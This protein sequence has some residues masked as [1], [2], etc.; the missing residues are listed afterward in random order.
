MSRQLDN[1]ALHFLL[2]FIETIRHKKTALLLE[3][4]PEAQLLRLATILSPLSSFD[5]H[6]YR[7][8]SNIYYLP[9]S[10]HNKKIK[11]F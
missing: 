11:Y 8:V 5:C 1:P 9:L 4:S 6:L 10:K 3:C 2:I 7:S